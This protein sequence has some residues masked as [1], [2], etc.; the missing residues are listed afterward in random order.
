MLMGAGGNLGLAVGNDAVFLIDDQ[1][2][3]LTPK[4]QARSLPEAVSSCSTHWHGDHTG[5][6]ALRRGG[7]DRA[8]TVRSGRRG[9]TM[10]TTALR[11]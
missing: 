2:A 8:M 1:Y 11:P 3:P 7:R 10:L 5:Q 6:R 9:V 4:I